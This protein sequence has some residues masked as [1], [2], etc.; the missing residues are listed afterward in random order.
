MKIQTVLRFCHGLHL[1]QPIYD[2]MFPIFWVRSVVSC[3]NWPI[4]PKCHHL[5]PPRTPGTRGTCGSTFGT[6]SWSPGRAGAFWTK[7]GVFPWHF[8]SMEFWNDISWTSANW[9]LFVLVFF[10][11]VVFPSAPE[12]RSSLDHPWHPKQPPRADG[13]KT[14]L[15]EKLELAELPEPDL[16]EYPTCPRRGPFTRN[17]E[18]EIFETKKRGAIFFLT[19]I[20]APRF[21]NMLGIFWLLVS[22]HRFSMTF[23]CFDHL[24]EARNWFQILP[25]EPW[26]GI[27]WRGSWGLVS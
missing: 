16:L 20:L 10:M 18:K 2:N 5:N 15:A 11:E 27:L 7:I 21:V 24:L 19:D 1:I 9:L 23:F 25:W 13:L 4:F 6:W 14:V 3:E 8:F 26:L 22:F 12:I 17:W